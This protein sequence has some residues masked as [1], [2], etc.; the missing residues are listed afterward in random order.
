MP[1]R[2]ASFTSASV[3]VS[4]LIPVLV[5]AQAPQA[6]P[7]P[8]GP[9]TLDQVLALAEPRSELMQVATQSV[10]RAEGD[11]VR[12]GAGLR[13]QLTVSTSYDRALASEFSGVFDDFFPSDGTDGLQDL[14]FGRVNT[15]RATVSFSQNLWSGGRN[16]AQVAV[17]ASGHET[18]SLGLSTTRAQLLFDA[19]QAYYDA[20]LSQRLVL[21]A[22]AT[23]EQAGET[24]R[25]TE[26]GLS[27]GTQPEFEVLRARVSRDSQLPVLIRQRVNRDIAH[28]RLKRIL[29]LPADYDL[30]L[31]D[32][33]GDENLPP[34]SVFAERV[35][36]VEKALGF[37]DPDAVTFQGTAALPMRTVVAQAASAVKLSEASLK[38]TEAQAMPSASLLSTYSR[39]AYPEDPFAPTFNRSNWTIGATL[40]VPVLTGGRQKGNELVARAELEQARLQQRQTEE[41]AALDTRSAWAELFAAQAAWAAT[42]GTVQQASRAYEIAEVRYTAGVSTQLELSDARLQRQQAEA[43]RARAARDLQVARAHVALLPDLPLGNTG[44]SAAATAAATPQAAPAPQA[45]TQ[46][47]GS[48]QIRNAFAQ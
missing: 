17:A 12:A 25:Q 40:S 48:A 43:N 19:T 21:I 1:D 31:A 9:L 14:P 7:V 22:A 41:L 10:R 11:E 29:D 28:L 44:V 16:G 23:L 6:P 24:L 45:P 35:V 26:A 4:L 34:P 37:A 18:A 47:S 2:R 32:A 27:A 8:P 38:L 30:Q 42:A 5:S 36:A 39:I 46:P 3:L 15:W 33:L 13:P 20:V